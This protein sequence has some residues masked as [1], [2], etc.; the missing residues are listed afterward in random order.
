MAALVVPTSEV[1]L[2]QVRALMRGFVAWC[3]VRYAEHLDQIDAYFDAG[4]FEAELAGLPGSYGPPRGCL[5]LAQIDGEAAGCVAYRPLDATSCEMKRMFVAPQFQGRGVGRALA[6]RLI[7][8]AGASGYSLM[9]LDTG[10]LQLEAQ[11]LYRS[12]GF[13]EI[14]PYY[15]VPDVV[16]AGALFME[17]AL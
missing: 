6:E 11:T 14:E 12:L 7:A 17:R 15:P 13:R 16:R 8:T 5:L 3:R 10:F 2:D 9:R 4:A 1:E